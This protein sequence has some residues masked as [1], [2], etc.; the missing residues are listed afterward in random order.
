[1]AMLA[2]VAPGC[3][4]IVGLSNV[5]NGTPVELRGMLNRTYMVMLERYGLYSAIVDVFDEELVQLGKGQMPEIVEVIHKAMDG[6]I[7]DLSS[8]SEKEAQ[9]V[10]TVR[11]LQ[12]ESLY[13]H[14]WLDI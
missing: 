14:S 1:M 11:V 12:G 2:D 4:S 9:Y 5:S 7:K 10:K 13:S 6:E 3:K 8:L